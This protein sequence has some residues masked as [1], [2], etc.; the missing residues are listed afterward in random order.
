MSAVLSV[1]AVFVGGFFGGLGRW[2]FSRWPGGR[3]GTF[4]ANVVACL[5]LGFAAGSGEVWSWAPLLVGVGFAAALSTWSTLAREL[6]DLVLARRWGVFARYVA[7]TVAV[8]LVAAHRGG[9]WAGRVWDN[10]SW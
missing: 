9:V 2:A 5:V 8:G 7:L 10:W 1:A 4:A 6:A 3:P